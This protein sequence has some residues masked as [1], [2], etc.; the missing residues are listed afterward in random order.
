[1][2]RLGF[3]CIFKLASFLLL[4]LLFF[5]TIKEVFAT[6]KTVPASY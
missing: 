1:M 4:L 5:L 6:Y 2:I 3:D